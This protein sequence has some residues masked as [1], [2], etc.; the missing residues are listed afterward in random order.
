[1][2]GKERFSAPEKKL[3]L[4]VRFSAGH[5]ELPVLNPI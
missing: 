2:Q 5:Q 4:K 3:T 1:M